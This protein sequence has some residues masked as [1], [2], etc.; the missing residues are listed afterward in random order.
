MYQSSSIQKN[1]DITKGWILAQNVQ[2]IMKIFTK[3]KSKEKNGTDMI[4]NKYS[5]K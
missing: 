5:S 2:I 4:W 1:T 3:Q